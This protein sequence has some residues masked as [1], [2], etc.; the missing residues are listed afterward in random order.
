MHVESLQHYS[1]DTAL[2]TFLCLVVAFVLGAIIGLERQYR[3]RNAGLRT[4]VLV[5]VGS[6]V[7]V[8]LAN[9][10]GGHAAAVH[11]IAYVV[12]G[13][14]FLGAGTIMKEGADVRGLNTAATLWGSAA[15]GACAGAS[16]LL[17]ATLAMVFV[18]AANTLLRPVVNWINR[19]PLDEGTSEVTYTLCV[20]VGRDDQK[21][22]M[23][24][25]ESLLDGHD[26]PVADL[27]VKPFGDEDIEI[28]ATLLS[29]S[30]SSDA[31]DHMLQH[32]HG[33]AFIKQAFWNPSAID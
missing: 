13:V 31:L 32:L 18:L 15:V 11:V 7:F 33:K 19:K 8:D 5:A 25:V 27:E 12:S 20:I 16:L 10:L 2:N 29:T 22:A 30:V 28:N 24:T 21:E 4:N 17:E 3:Q 1:A 6:A 26:Y 23:I 9:Q 14:G